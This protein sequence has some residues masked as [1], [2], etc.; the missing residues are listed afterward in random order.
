MQDYK[1]LIVWQKSHA[2]ALQLYK[3]TQVF[4]K[5]ERYG[6]TSQM[7]RSALSIPA[8][9]AEGCERL[10]DKESR[11][12]FQISL[13]SLHE[14]EYYLLFCKGLNYINETIFN[15][16]NKKIL[17]EVKRMLIKLIQINLNRV[18]YKA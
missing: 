9:I 4:P 13:G 18:E 7:R 2:F 5:E 3:E 1:K 10:T 14:T 16:L 8:N 6:I 12:F 15:D 17:T 11:Q